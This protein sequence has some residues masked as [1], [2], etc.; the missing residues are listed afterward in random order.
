MFSNTDAHNAKDF[1]T[2][3]I[4]PQP[5]LF[6][7]QEVAATSEISRLTRL[8]DVLP[9]GE[10]L[11]VLEAE[12]AGKRNDYPL[13]ALWRALLAGIV[14]GHGSLASL[15]RELARNG[16]LR[17]LCGFDPLRGDQAVPPA[18]IWTRF[19]AKLLRHA[20]L[21]D[22]LFARLI[23]RLRELLPDFGRDLAIDGKAIGAWSKL[24]PEASVGF[25]NYEGEDERGDPLQKI[26]HW[27]GYKLH[28]LIDANY[29]LPVAFE[30]TGAKE[31]ESPLLLPL[32]EKLKHE[33]PELHERLESLAADRG[34]DDGGDKAALYDDHAIVPLIDTRDL[35]GGR[36]QPLDENHHDTIYFSPT[37][38]VSCKVD[39]FEPLPEKAFA[40]MQFMGF[41]RERAALKF[42]CPAAA[43]GLE[44]KNREACRCAPAVR[45]GAY[46]RVVRVPL[47]RD[48]RI[49]L[50][51][52]RHSRGFI[53]GYNK[54]TAVERVNSRIDQVYGFEHHFIRG[55]KKVRLRLGLALLVMLGTALA[56]VE[57]KQPENVRSL[58]RA[59]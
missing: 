1:S 49:F 22:A 40:A 9:D 36:M 43:F 41:E 34:Y 46:G 5:G 47:E 6:S 7:W 23:E 39:P 27:F 44:C 26:Q 31:G 54:R 59:A 16:Q 32:L 29:E 45:E 10:L 35:H 42:R 14:F 56:W 17:D 38:E 12:R 2:M 15:G 4:L 11:A 57:M 30:L 21:I 19:I 51:L 50:P 20:D 55:K 48:R 13:A 33:H 53:E 52:H 37:G 25:K 8:L 18:W 28:L 3:S 58:V 24:D